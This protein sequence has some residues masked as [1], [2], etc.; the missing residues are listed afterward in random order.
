MNADKRI[1]RDFFDKQHASHAGYKRTASDDLK[2]RSRCANCG[3]MGQWAENCRKP[4]RSKKER[5]A[6]EKRTSASGQKE[7]GS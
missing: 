6:A 5:A 3:D 4:F 2:R 1:E 7:T